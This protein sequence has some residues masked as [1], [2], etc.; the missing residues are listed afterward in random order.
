MHYNVLDIAQYIIQ[1][2]NEQNICINNLKLQ[3]AKR[4]S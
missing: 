2:Y 3:K 4:E 1:K